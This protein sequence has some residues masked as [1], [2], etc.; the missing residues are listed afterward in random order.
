MDRTND[1]TLVF[2][3]LTVISQTFTNQPPPLLMSVGLMAV[4]LMEVGVIVV[5]MVTV[6]I[7]A[8]GQVLLTVLIQ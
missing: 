7:V 1:Q 8:A 6:G 2:V 4:G 3:E 5:G